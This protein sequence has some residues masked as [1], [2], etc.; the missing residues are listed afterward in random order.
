MFVRGQ[1]VRLRKGS[2]PGFEEK[3]IHAVNDGVIIFE[4]GKRLRLDDPAWDIEVVNQY[5]LSV[6]GAEIE[7]KGDFTLR[8]EDYA[9]GDVPEGTDSGQVGDLVFVRDELGLVTASRVVRKD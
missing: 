2:A 1:T 6:E 8:R 5:V 9:L 4:N 3:R 7:L